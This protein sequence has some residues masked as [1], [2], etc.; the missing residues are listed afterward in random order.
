LAMRTS[1]ERLHRG[2]IAAMAMWGQ[3]LI[4]NDQG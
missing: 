4:S 3:Q 2:R 1:R